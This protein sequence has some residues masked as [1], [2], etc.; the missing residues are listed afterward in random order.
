M[1]LRLVVTTG[2][3]GY[4]RGS[5]ISD[6]TIISNIRA[7]EYAA[8]VVLVSDTVIPPPDPPT[9]TP[10]PGGG[11]SMDDFLVLR[12]QYQV[13]A[14][15]DVQQQSA[16]AALLSVNS[17]QTD[18]IASLGQQLYQLNSA[19]IVLAAKIDNPNGGNPLP[20]SLADDLPLAENDGVVL[21]TN[22]NAVLAGDIR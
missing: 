7:S 20:P 22:S 13:L 8:Q 21:A 17:S 2:F 5:I 15:S 18:A 1:A 16:L 19:I 9:G 3:P 12:N 14:A 10:L 6:P 11:V 4:A